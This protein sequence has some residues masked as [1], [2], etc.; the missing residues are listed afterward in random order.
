MVTRFCS[1]SQFVTGFEHKLFASL[2]NI[3]I[4]AYI[5]TNV[6]WRDG[7]TQDVNSW[8]YN[9][10]TSVRNEC[11]IEL[12]LSFKSSILAQKVAIHGIIK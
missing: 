6:I 12:V 4:Y 8:I 5:E 3:L 10:A 1:D 2:Y 11:V 7:R 9:L